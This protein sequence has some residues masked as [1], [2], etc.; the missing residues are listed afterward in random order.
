MSKPSLRR[1]K[2]AAVPTRKISETIIDFGAPL[3]EQLHG[4]ETPDVV[5][6]TFSLVVTVWNAHVMAMP[7]LDRNP[8][9]EADAQRRAVQRPFDVMH[10]ERIPRQGPF[11]GR[12]NP[13]RA[14]FALRGA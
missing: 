4:R 12:A 8:G 3:L 11:R 5:Q 10:R 6:A 2:R 7:P 1:D 14:R 9:R 13:S